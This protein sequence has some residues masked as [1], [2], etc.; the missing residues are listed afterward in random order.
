MAGI[1]EWSSSADGV[2]LISTHH[3]GGEDRRAGEVQASTDRIISNKVIHFQAVG[4]KYQELVKQLDS[5]QP[6]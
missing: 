2:A 1:R 5:S 3:V 4:Y 6:I